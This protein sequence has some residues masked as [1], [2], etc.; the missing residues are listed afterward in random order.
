MEFR[1][2]S[3]DLAKDV[4]EVAIANQRYQVQERHRFT[5]TQFSRFLASQA[6]ALVLMEAC[7]GAHYWGRQ[8]QGHGHRVDVLPAQYVKPYRRRG[9]SDR[10]DTKAL[11]QAHRH[12]GLRRFTASSSQ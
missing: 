12:G 5:R 9:K 1:F 10:I 3:V 11:L 7:G 4:F 8:A 2:I 6:P